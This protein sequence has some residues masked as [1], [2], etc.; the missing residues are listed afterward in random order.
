MAERGVLMKTIKDAIFDF[1]HDLAIEVYQEHDNIY[2]QAAERTTSDGYHEGDDV[3][4]MEDNITDVIS[5]M[6]EEKLSL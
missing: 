2:K 6:I 5:E 3:D 4:V 1:A